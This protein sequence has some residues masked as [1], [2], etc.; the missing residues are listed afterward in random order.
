MKFTI[1]VEEI[2]SETFEIEAGD[3]EEAIVIAEEQYNK[4]KIVLE[5]GNLIAKKM[6]IVSPDDE[7]TEWIE[8]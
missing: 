4:G 8:F 7:A 1:V 5:P 6:A 2:V 3:A